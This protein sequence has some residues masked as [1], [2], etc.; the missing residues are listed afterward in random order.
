MNKQDKALYHPDLMEKWRKVTDDMAKNNNLSRCQAQ[1][2][3]LQGLFFIDELKD[4]G[5]FR[6]IED[7]LIGW[8]VDELMKTCQDAQ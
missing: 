6:V 5:L 4:P 2:F 7:R 3:A 1:A 8:V